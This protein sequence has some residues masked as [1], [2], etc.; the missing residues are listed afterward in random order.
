MKAT[1]KNKLRQLT[2]EASHLVDGRWWFWCGI[3]G[4]GMIIHVGTAVL[5]LDSF[6]PQPQV[7]DFAAYYAG[8]WAIR[9]Q[10]KSML[11]SD[12]LLQFLRQNQ[13]LTIT[14]PIL[15]SPPAWP[16]LLQPF[17]HL[18]FL[19]AAIL[20]LCLL[21]LLTIYTHQLL[22]K[23]AGYG[24]NWK[25]MIITFPLTLTFGPLFLNLTLGQ[26][27]IFLLLSLAT[28][29]T[30]LQFQTTSR[31]YLYAISLL[32]VAITAKLFPT[33][34]LACLIVLR[35]WRLLLV[36]SVLCL[37]VFGF[38]AISRPEINQEYWF[39]FLPGRNQQFSIEATVDDQSL[40]GFL[41]R[42]GREGT[43]KFPGLSVSDKHQVTWRYPW[44]FSAKAIQLTSYSLLFVLGLGLIFAWAN[45]KGQ[46]AD[47]I[48]YSLALFS[49]LLLAHMERYNH[50]I[51]L[52]AMAWLWRQKKRKI[53]LL[54]YSF[55]G[56]SRL[57]HLLALLPAPL[58]PVATGFGLLAILVL[59]LG[60]AHALVN[61]SAAGN[62]ILV[63]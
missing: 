26:N 59:M 42:I 30:A 39:D 13:H 32:V 22:V 62:P 35:R 36:A 49:V 15:N 48:L 51:A 17:T 4:L 44:N 50:I 1:V 54:A 57:T 63:E 43:Y 56:L 47:A 34:W 60:M 18:T 55:F 8:A 6:W 10:A 7:V 5:R 2:V 28:L 33:I 12:D 24:N 41:T 38:I 21:L 29:G 20:W 27:G 37:S 9:R 23:I 45:N 31:N 58:G 11:W 46:D 25:L 52:P 16:W 14:P 3:A 19:P 40:N 53:V 61:Y